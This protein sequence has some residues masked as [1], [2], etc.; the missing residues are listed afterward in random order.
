[1]KK[2][3]SIALLGTLIS[4]GAFAATPKDTLVVAKNIEDIVSLDPA[5]AFEFSSG[6]VV[7]N[8]YEGLIQYDAKDPSK[9]QPAIAASW[10]AGANGKS[11]EFVLRPGAVF[12]G[13]NPIRYEDVLFSFR[14]VLKLNKAPA[15][16]L[17]QL[18]WNNDN[19]TQM[20]TRTPTGVAVAWSG[21]F[22]PGYVLNVLAA[23]PGNVVDE[24][25]VMQNETAGDLGNGWLKGNSAGSGPFKLKL[26]KPKEVVL[27]EAN[28]Q[29]ADAP[30][31]ASILFRNV[32]EPAT[33]RL[34]IESNDADI[35]RDLGPDQI[36]ALRA[37]KDIRIEDYPQAAV[38][39]ISL[40]LKHEKLRN[41]ALWEA[42]RYLVDYEG[43]S[44][45]LLKNQM[46][47][48]QAFLPV[49][50]AGALTTTP[51]KLDPERAKGILTKAGINGIE[52]NMDLINSPKFMDMAQSMQ[53]SMA[54]AGIKLNLLPGTGAQ[55]I[56]RY[57]ARQHETMLLYWG[58]D[59][60]DP[61]SNAKAFAYNVD[62]SDASYQSTTTWRNS[63]LIPELSAKTLVALKEAD[64]A[65]RAADYLA[66]QQEVQARSPIIMTFQ[67]QSQVAFRNT[68]KGYVQ[69]SV[70]DL[71]KYEGVT[72]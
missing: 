60:F 35:A 29:G 69:G 11:M 55:V 31:L 52:M 26:Y 9:I 70:A 15:F 17:A 45:Q 51:F 38:H 14:R 53:A 32:T 49:G 7:S 20:V 27:L 25:T 12:A 37:N 62:N 72:K 48:H 23:R 28:K 8:V 34:L 68:V 54:K 10:K 30:K 44:K 41:P 1:M 47:V 16:I 56:T 43:I 5:E 36:Q 13:G 40:N 59:F 65:K 21:D 50:F 24:K 61:H 42:M 71:I 2:R 64:P 4:L 58:P 67:E 18:G 57:R 39:F 63:W 33:Q 66:L 46:R 3:L 19:I 6:E 22:G